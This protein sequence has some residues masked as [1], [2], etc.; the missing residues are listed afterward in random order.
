MKKIF[1][2]LFLFLFLLSCGKKEKAIEIDNENNLSDN[3][4]EEV[5]VKE[6]KIIVITAVGDIMLGSNYPSDSS[7]PPGNENILKE[8]ETYLKDSDIT[9]GNLEGTLFDSGGNPKSCSN[10]SVCYVFRTPSVFGQYL[11]DSGFDVVSIA[12]N[13]NGDFGPVGRAKTKENLD[14]L[15][16][17][18][19]GLADTDEFIIFE[20]DGIK[21]GFAAFA[22]N[23]GTVSINDIPYAEKLI[24]QLK[25]NSDIV[26][27][28]FH[29]G[30]EGDEYQHVPK[31]T[32][33][34]FGENRG[35]V[36]EF[37]RKMVEAGADIVFGHGPH[38]IRAV[39]LYNDKFIS[40][41]SGNFATYGNFNL[42]GVKGIAPLFKIKL[43]EN[44]NFIEGKIISTYQVKGSGPKIDHKKRALQK[45]IELTENDFP[46][47]PL[48]FSDDGTITK[49]K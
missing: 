24:K 3:I 12:N 47:T 40:Y 37:A 8:I 41:S 2:F 9:F 38:V 20:K 14:N 35:D 13:H 48:S 5:P 11:V 25:E 33:T 43:D 21:Y 34:F 6:K 30:A 49:K 23:N 1:I 29:G 7:L 10:P 19:A 32:E 45:I 22:P 17:K 44:G 31:R 16:I 4:T 39:E 18:Y 36:H 46:D 28:S 26:I 15:G 27:V 42:S